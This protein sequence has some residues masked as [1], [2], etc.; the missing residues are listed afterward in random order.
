MSLIMSLLERFWVKLMISHTYK[1]IQIE[2][3]RLER[4]RESIKY[5]EERLRYWNNRLLGVSYENH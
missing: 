2:K 3:D 1:T 4:V 5:D